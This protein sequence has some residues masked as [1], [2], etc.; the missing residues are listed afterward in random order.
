MRRTEKMSLKA[1]WDAVER[2]LATH[3]ADEL[4][5]ILRGMAQETPPM[6]RQAF[7]A[8]LKPAAE[9]DAVVQRAM[10]QEDL[11]ADIDDLASELK[12][13]MDRAEE[14]WEQDRY[15]WDDYGEYDEEDSL[16][17]YEEFVEPL[18][19]LFDRTE[20]VFD[21][22]NL[23]LARKAY[24]KL[25]EVLDLEDDYGRGISMDD[26]DGV[27]GEVA[28]RYLRAVYETESPAR[29]PKSLFEQMQQ[30]HLRPTGSR[31]M[32]NDLIEI[33]TQPLPDYDRFVEAWIAFLRKQDGSYADALLREAV[34]LSQGAAGL[35]ELA[36]AEGKK[37]PRAYLDWF[38]ALEKENQYRDVLAAAQEALQTLPS[39]LPIRAAVA[40]H[41]C[42]AAAQLDE[43][44]ALRAGRWEAFTVKPTLARLLDL[45]NVAPADQ[46][47]AALMQQ[48]AQ[49]VKGYLAHP[50]RRQETL[51]YDWREDN[52]EAVAW[53]D[54][55]VLAHA[56]LLAGDWDSA[57]QLAVREKSLGWSSS[58]NPQGLVAPFFFVLLSGKPA[59]ALPPNLAKLWQRALTINAGF[60]Y[61]DEDDKAEGDVHKRLERA[62]AERLA[63]VSLSSDKQQ[64]LLSWCLRVA[65][66]RTD[67]IVGNLHRGSYDK[68]AE[69]TAASAEVLRLQ[70]NEQ[71]ADAVLD[72]ARNRYPRHRAFQSE[73]DMA[74]QRMG[75]SPRRKK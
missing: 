15:G 53:I 67:D 73:L 47:Q 63:N 70:G 21:H 57:H 16:G 1:F 36:H 68:A 44:D 50:P 69:L 46:E 22:G 7:L 12:S 38:A 8:K 64:E 49:Y 65:K 28:A 55:S 61:E 37:R 40:D 60:D 33:S 32:L 17:P 51:A 14:P 62:Y 35:E 11:L 72:D 42:A 59:N 13:A 3:S 24:Q 45:W 9:V 75:R 6:G 27:D 20:A 25:F 30:S 29:R 10:G 23:K 19:A 31:P 39:K 54:K 56:Y 34:R 4:K 41:L 5:S 66:Q 26:L 52:L 2:K 18:S 48:S 74:M 58:D 71:E 43:K